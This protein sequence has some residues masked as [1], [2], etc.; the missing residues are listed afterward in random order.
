MA[1]SP[2]FL[3]MAVAHPLGSLP[4]G[5]ASGTGRILP[6]GT[7][8]VA[9]AAN[10]RGCP[11]RWT[12]NTC[13]VEFKSL[14]EQHEDPMYDLHRLKVAVLRPFI[15]QLGKFRI[16]P[17]DGSLIQSRTTCFYT[18]IRPDRL[19]TSPARDSHSQDMDKDGCNA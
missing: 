8:A 15:T 13:G 16:E 5:Y 3:S 9:A 7:G 14:Q 1:L 17:V 12:C 6:A 11:F 10:A 19:S 18:Y 2:L 4:P